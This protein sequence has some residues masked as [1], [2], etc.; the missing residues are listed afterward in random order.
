[1]LGRALR[2]A[3]TA[4][5]FR[6]VSVQGGK[7]WNAIPRDATAIWLLPPG[8]EAGFRAAVES[9]AEAIRDAYAKTDPGVTVTVTAAP[10][11]R[12]PG[13]SGAGYWM[14]GVFSPG[15]RRSPCVLG[16]AAATG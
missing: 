10:R 4:A 3:L 13:A 2:E 15:L 7:S 8:R 14:K 9:A 16:M 11:R 1:V 5:P 6:L 12:T